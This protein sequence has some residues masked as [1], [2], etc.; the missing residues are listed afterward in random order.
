MLDLEHARK[1][2]YTFPSSHLLLAMDMMVAVA[3]YSFYQI[4]Q[5]GRSVQPA[6]LLPAT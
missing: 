3:Q 6:F 4:L 1:T 5:G 2:Q